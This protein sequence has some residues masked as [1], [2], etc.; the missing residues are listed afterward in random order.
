MSAMFCMGYCVACRAFIAFNPVHVP[1]LT[2]NGEREPLCRSCAELWRTIHNR[3]DITIHKDA[4][5]TYD[6][7]E[8]SHPR[9]D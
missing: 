6:D 7:A 2:V 3:P 1:S 5:E 4:Y 9:D 8:S